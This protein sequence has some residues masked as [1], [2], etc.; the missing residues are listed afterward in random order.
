MFVISY[1]TYIYAHIYIC[2]TYVDIR[3]TW[4]MTVSTYIP[5]GIHVF[6]Q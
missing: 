3:L 2:N 5:W 1:H 6:K 4:Q